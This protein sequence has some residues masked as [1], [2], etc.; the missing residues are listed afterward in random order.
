[1]YEHLGVDLLSCFGGNTLLQDDQQLLT[2][3]LLLLEFELAGK[4]GGFCEHVFDVFG[5]KL[6]IWVFILV[7]IVCKISD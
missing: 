5:W 4:T 3:R 1:M 6:N 2:Q 7:T